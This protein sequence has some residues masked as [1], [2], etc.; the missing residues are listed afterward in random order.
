MRFAFISLVCA[1]LAAVGCQ[2]SP[3]STAAEH[4]EHQ[5]EGAEQSVSTEAAPHTAVITVYGMGCPQCANNVDLQL[6]RVAGVESVTIDM[7]SG[8]VF[9]K[10]TPQRYPTRDQLAQAI[11]ETGFTLVDITMPQ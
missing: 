5:A 3:E 9:A 1:A 8:Q 11:N 10:L 6:M 4:T 2:S 7:G